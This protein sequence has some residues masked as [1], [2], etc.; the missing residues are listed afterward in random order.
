MKVFSIVG[1]DTE[2]GK[3]HATVEI[4]N[5][6]NNNCRA[7]AIKP[8]AAGLDKIDGKLIN[9]DVYRIASANHSIIS[10]EIISP[11]QFELAIAPHIAAQYQQAKL[12]KHLV[13]N[14]IQSSIDSIKNINVLHNK[15]SSSMNKKPPDYILIEGVGGIMVPLNESETYLNV[16]QQLKHPVILVVGMKLGCL[17][18]ALLTYNM[19]KTH[20][21]QIEGW[22]ANC[23]TPNMPYLKENIEYLERAIRSPLLA[24]IPYNNK[25][26][27]TPKFKEIFS[28]T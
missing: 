17:N 6:L 24:T 22:I 1:T 20:N 3:T 26:E 11:L 15:Y 19:L 8:I 2:I 13:I 7:F 25:I 10:N 9:E 12:N 28:C 16:L 18:H 4:L 23:I 5:Y 27:I 21:V 14:K